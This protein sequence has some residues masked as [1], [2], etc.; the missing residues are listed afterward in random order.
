[1]AQ[2]KALRNR[3]TLNEDNWLE[4]LKERIENL[5]WKEVKRDIRPFLENPDEIITFNQDNMMLLLSS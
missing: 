1:L 2:V 5:D 4:V 3:V